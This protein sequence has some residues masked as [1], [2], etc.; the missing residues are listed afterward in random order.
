MYMDVL[1]N[2]NFEEKSEISFKMIAKE[3]KWFD[4]EDFASFIKSI[5]NVW[6]VITGTSLSYIL[7]NYINYCI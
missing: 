3:K 7:L 6:C 5:I 1:V 4:F 2:G